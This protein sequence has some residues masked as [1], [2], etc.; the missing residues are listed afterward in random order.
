ML[1]SGPRWGTS[2]GKH[3][4]R[5]SSASGSLSGPACC[6]PERRLAVRSALGDAAWPGTRAGI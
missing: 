1:A 6:L 5:V 3:L 4:C 2:P